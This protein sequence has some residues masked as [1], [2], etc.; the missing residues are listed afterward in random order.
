MLISLLK[1]IHTNPVASMEEIGRQLSVSPKLVNSM[2][3][4]LSKRGYL[5]AYEECASACENC[6]LSRTCRTGTRPKI[7]SLTE[8]GR[9]LAQNSDPK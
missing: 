1:I 9:G 5:K 2:V 7:W 8:K 4:D 3:A 6:P